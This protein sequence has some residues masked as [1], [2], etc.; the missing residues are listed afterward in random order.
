MNPISEN[1]LAH[2]GVRGMKWGH[3][4]A[5]ITDRM[6]ETSRYT[7][8]S[9]LHPILTS[10]AANASIRGE[11]LGTQARR[12]YLHQTTKEMKDVSDRVDKMLAKK[13]K[14]NDIKKQYAKEYMAGK[15]AVGKAIA[16]ITAGDKTYADTMYN[17]NRK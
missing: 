13:A 12:M 8:N 11:K 3:R 15:S 7:K 10:R 16:K 17:L 14:I 9:T 5:A 1:A 2:I 4:K 6:H